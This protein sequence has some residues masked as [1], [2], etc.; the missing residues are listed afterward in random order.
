MQYV[1]PDIGTAFHTVEDELRDAF[2]LALFKGITFQIPV[3]AVTGF[4]VNW[5]GI[6]IP[7]PNQTARANWA[8]SC[9][10]TGNLVA[11]IRRMA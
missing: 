6:A 4:P 7:N 11:D 8:A 10:I 5:S 1:V 3:R 2:L 9:V